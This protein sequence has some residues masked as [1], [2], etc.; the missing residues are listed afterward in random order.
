MQKPRC[1]LGLFFSV[2]C[3]SP[4][5]A[6]EPA[7]PNIIFILCDDLGYGDVGVFF[8][9]QRAKNNQPG[10]PWHMTPRLDSMAAAG[11]QMPHHYCPAPVCAPSRASLLTGVHQ[12][13]A[14]VR[15]NQFDKALEDNHTLASVL[16]QAGYATAAFG[17]W[18]LQGKGQTEQQWPAHPLKRGFDFYYGY[19]RHKD[20]HAQFPKEDGKE[21]WENFEEVST[22]LDKCYTTDLFTA[23][24][25]KWIAEQRAANPSQP[26]F[27]YLAY[28]TPHAKL[29]LPS[30]AYPQGGGLKGG[31][32]WLGT[33]G[34]MINT[35]EGEVDGYFH[36]DYAKATWDHD[37]DA[38]TP[39]IA[40]PDVQKRYATDVRRIDD[41]VG[42]V[43]QLLKDLKIEDNTLVVFTTDNGPSKESYLQE[44]Y[45]PTF[46]DTYGPFAGIKRDLWEGG[47]RVGA[48]VHWP[49]GAP[50]GRVS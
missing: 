25:K 43:L 31:V 35:A 27:A 45:H 30:T 17:K 22:G 13:H 36:P 24:A 26:F 9:N 47:I 6:A 10:Q 49:Q 33:P 1:L 38:T 3:A 46:F 5:H 32:Q 4:L 42:D 40:W 37:T 2:L 12:G 41:C 39:E 20:G 8:Q 34:R 15:D 44:P 50:A 29:Q 11:V 48:L 28:S 16:K 14:G 18:G 21:V 7:K 19:M 23:R